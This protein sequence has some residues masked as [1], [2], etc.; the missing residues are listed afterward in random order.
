M[1]AHYHFPDVTLLIT[2]YNRSNSLERLLRTFKERNCTFEDVVVSDDG[3]KP[4]HLEAIKEL[5]KQ[6]SF[7]LITTP[8][9]QGLGNNINK[10]QDAVRTAY[11]L[12][13][14]EDF[15]PTAIFVTHFQDALQII[16]K[17]DKW[18]I[19]RFYSYL[20]YPHC[21]PYN[22]EFGEMIYK[23]WSLKRVKLFF[24]SDHPHLRRRNFLEKFG[25]YEEGGNHRKTEYLMCVNFIRKKGKGLF[26]KEYKSLFVQENSATE[27][28]TWREKPWKT[29]KNPAIVFVRY[30]YRQIKYN[31]DLNF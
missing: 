30:V 10:G 9:N 29:S 26:F 8:A 20:P 28:S 13:V 16:N 24:Y 31:Y 27:P 4:A 18:D 1:T 6:F 3:S 22:N 14:Q 11:T 23:P 7:N 2:H 19:I 17:E 12:Y 25:R 15:M 5:K 21:K